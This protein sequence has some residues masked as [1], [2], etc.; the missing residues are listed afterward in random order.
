MEMVNKGSV[1]MK[2]LCGTDI[3]EI[4]RIKRAIQRKED[5]FLEEIYT[6]L[7]IDYCKSKRNAMYESF[8]ARF[9]AKEAVLKIVYNL[10]KEKS[11][12]SFKNIE[13]VNN[14]NG[15]PQIQFNNIEFSQ[16]QSIDVSISHC[17]KYATANA[18]AIIE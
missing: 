7:E 13:I 17:K 11:Y 15:K 6:K 4:D 3:I 2:V 1:M 5:K 10:V 12:V 16:I 14:K 18:I 9:A 8:A